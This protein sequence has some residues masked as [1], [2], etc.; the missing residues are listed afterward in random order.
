MACNLGQGVQ[1]VE[2]VSS[3]DDGVP[4]QAGAQQV[5]GQVSGQAASVG[6]HH[7][8]QLSIQLRQV[9]E[10]RSHQH[11][12]CIADRIIAEPMHV[13]GSQLSKPADHLLIVSTS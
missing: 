8:H 10:A 5:N 3:S 7:A 13:W 9:E 11:F 2:Q 1:G 12:T 6:C 4:Q